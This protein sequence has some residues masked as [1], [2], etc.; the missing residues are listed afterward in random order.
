MKTKISTMGP[1]RN[2]YTPRFI[3]L[4]ALATMLL[5]A[6]A[7]AHGQPAE[8][9]EVNPVGAYTL[10]SVDGKD[11]PCTI[12]HEGTA[13]IVHAGT[14]TIAT[15]GQI[16]SV[17]IFSVGDRK[18]LRHETHATYKMKNAELTMKWK[19]AG[20]TKGRIVGQTFTMTNEGM[21][22]VYKQ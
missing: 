22:Y 19:N 8:K 1:A 21:A 15:N 9:K 14:F 7:R 3:A 6:L 10:V 2:N 18:N 16:T 17:M 12:N 20:M 13:M 4:A 11:V 5:S